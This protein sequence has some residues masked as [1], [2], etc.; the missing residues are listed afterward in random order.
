MKTYFKALGRMFRKNLSR[1]LSIILIVLISISLTSGIG[2]MTSKIKNSAARF[3]KDRNVSDITVKSKSDSGF[4]DGQISSIEKIYGKEN[5][6]VGSS[7]EVYLTVNGK[8][9]LTRLY[10]SDDFD[11][12][13]VNRF[14][15]DIEP[16]GAKADDGTFHAFAEKSDNEII[17][18]QIGDE[19]TL[20]YKDIY[21]QLAEENGTEITAESEQLLSMLPKVTATIENI[22]EDPRFFAKEGEPSYK[23]GDDTD[24]GSIGTSGMITL[25]DILYLPTEALLALPKANEISISLQS[26]YDDWL[27][28]P[29]YESLIDAEKENI[30]SILSENGASEDSFTFITLHENFSFYSLSKYA[31]KIFGLSIVLMVAFMF[32]TALVVLSNVTRLME[33]ERPQTACLIS[34]GYSASG[35]VFK[36]LLFVLAATAIGGYAAYFIGAGLCSFVYLVFDYAYVMPPETGV[37]AVTFFFITFSFIIVAA[38]GATI[39]T[40][41]KYARETPAALMRPKAPEAGKKVV[42]ERIPFIWNRL[43]FKYKSTFRNVLRY[44]N[45]FLMTVIAV[46]GSMG[47][48]MAG[49]ALLDMCLFGDFGNAAIAGLSV[50][51]VAF[52][53]LLTLTAI[54][55]ITNISISERNREIATLM[56]LGYYDSEVSG[57]IYREIYIDAAFGI[58]F[59]YGVGAILIDTVFRVMS[60]GSLAGVS[61]YV[62]LIAPVIVLIFTLLVTLILRRQIVSVDMNASLKA[63]E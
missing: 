16:V 60:F 27:F 35:V 20:D 9:R 54:Y 24:F 49:L 46:A 18:Y 47:L 29:S 12:R 6:S 1:F 33:E 56:V 11:D 19:I 10:F 48:V 30:S 58:L 38:A 63:I 50:V 32:I 5:V 15:D 4:T 43:S 23:N 61:W 55:T 3:A 42:I 39:I 14:S 28:M 2:S 62:W 8:E 31:D 37:F 21:T 51:I 7:F 36:Y 53:A 59:G 34:L 40:G 52:A 57:Y 13:K 17:G 26:E 22:V 41:S 44:R 25:D 45:R